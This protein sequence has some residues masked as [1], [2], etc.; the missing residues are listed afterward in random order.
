MRTSKQK[1]KSLKS[2]AVLDRGL[3]KEFHQSDLADLLTSQGVVPQ[4][5]RPRERLT[6]IFL[7]PDLIEKLREKG[8]K[9]GIGYQTML[10]IIVHENV[11]KY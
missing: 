5:V 1:R 3:E 4:A 7:P 10:K 11:G 6:S 8:A 9:R 2:Q